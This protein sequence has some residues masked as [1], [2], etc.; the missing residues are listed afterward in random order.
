M[1]PSAC[2]IDLKISSITALNYVL[3]HSTLYISGSL[4]IDKSATSSPLILNI[5]Y[6][7]QNSTNV[8]YNIVGSEGTSTQKAS[9]KPKIYQVQNNAIG[10]N[11]ATFTITTSEN[12][13]VY[14]SIIQAGTP[15]DSITQESIYKRTI[16]TSITYGNATASVNSLKGVNILANFTA[17]GLLAQKSFL[18]AVFVNSTIGNSDIT[19]VL[20]N[21]TKSS[22]G[23]AI[24]IS[25]NSIVNSTAFLTYL[26]NVLRIDVSRIS[27]LTIQETLLTSQANYVSSV[28]NSRS[29]VYDVILGPNQKDDSVKPLDTLNQFIASTYQIQMLLGFVPQLITAY[30]MTT[31]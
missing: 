19:F 12:G 29:Y 31:R 18:L 21:T 7:P 8:G 4:S 16:S 3:D 23:A 14:Y 9:L 10:S 28:M 20:F 11:T 22:N 2:Q 13:T 1:V 5:T 6:T 30:T 25:L 26:S 24:K 15:T 17:T 27:I